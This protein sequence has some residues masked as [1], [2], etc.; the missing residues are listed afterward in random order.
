[1][2][3]VPTA[4]QSYVAGKDLVGYC[5]NVLPLRFPVKNQSFRDY[6]TSIKKVFLNGYDHQFYPLSQLL[7]QLNIKRDPSRPPL[8]TTLVG[9]DK[10]GDHLNFLGLEVEGNTNYIGIARREI[11]WNIVETNNQLLLKL[12]YNSDIYSA[13]TIRQWMQQFET[14]LQT[15]IKQ[16]DLWLDVNDLRHPSFAQKLTKS[17][18]QQQIAEEQNLEAT[19]I[20]KLK[21]FQRKAIKY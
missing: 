1:V 20:Q 9:M 17:D 18:R 7:K 13:S 19:S 11:T 12:N 6:L 2:I 3:G 8:I 14:I 21:N 10:F 16:P 5:A 15:A 4:G